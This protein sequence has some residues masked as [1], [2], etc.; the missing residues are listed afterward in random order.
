MAG[1]AAISAD[2]FD[3]RASRELVTILAGGV[4]GITI[5]GSSVTNIYGPSAPCHTSRL[6][7]R[8]RYSRYA[9]CE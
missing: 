6:S 9:R 5:N 3:P 4:R 8:A 7:V 1:A 2:E